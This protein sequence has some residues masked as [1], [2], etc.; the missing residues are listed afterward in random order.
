MDGA[1]PTARPLR[2]AHSVLMIAADISGVRTTR[3]IRANVRAEALNILVGTF[4]KGI[5]SAKNVRQR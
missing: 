2:I 1:I 3:H 5:I 4:R